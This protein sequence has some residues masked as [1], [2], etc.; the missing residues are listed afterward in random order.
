MD[1]LCLN[2]QEEEKK[3]IKKIIGE[4][5]KT[6]LHWLSFSL[7]LCNTQPQCWLRLLLLGAKVIWR[8]TCNNFSGLV[9]AGQVTKLGG[10][11]CDESG[12]PDSA[13]CITNYC[14]AGPELKGKST[15]LVKY[16]ASLKGAKLANFNRSKKKNFV[17]LI[18]TTEV[19]CC[20]P[21]K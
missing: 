9:D 12:T 10:M 15:V 7:K 2:S 6:T 5:K 18:T 17:H 13:Q 20:H 3:C 8:A 16:S 21:R 1:K 4:K 11:R 19:H 14:C